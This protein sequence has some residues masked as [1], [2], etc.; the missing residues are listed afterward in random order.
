MNKFKEILN[1]IGHEDILQNNP[2]HFGT[3]GQHTEAVCLA[4]PKKASE[5][6]RAAALLHDIGKIET[7]SIN[8]KNGYDQFIGHATKSVEMIDI[9][10]LLSD[11]S[12]EKSE[13]IKELVRLHDT[14]Y[15]KENKCKTMLDNHPA[16]FAA[17]LITLQFADVMGQSAYKRAEKLQEIINFASLINRVGAPDQVIGV[18]DLI[19]IIEEV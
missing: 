11:F 14:K 1:K 19:S 3:V 6:L 18:A 5:K 16:G 8:P 4:L 17:D 2:H 15:S 7:R 13:Y 12:D 9:Y 10:N